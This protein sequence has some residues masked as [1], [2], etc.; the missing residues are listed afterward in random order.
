MIRIELSAEKKWRNKHEWRT[1]PT[2]VAKGIKITSEGRL[3]G[4]LAEELI[5]A[6]HSAQELCEVWR[7]ETICFHSMP[8]EKWANGKALS[9]RQ[10][11]HLRK[12]NV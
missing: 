9:G 4:K 8:L 6:G 7:G 10:P 2:A 5:Q 11:E 1:L 3:I 12:Q